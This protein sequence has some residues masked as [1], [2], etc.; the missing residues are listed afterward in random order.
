MDP[1]TRCLLDCGMLLRDQSEAHCLS[2]VCK[3][4][5]EVFV[6]VVIGDLMPCA[7]IPAGTKEVGDHP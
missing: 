3:V 1:G 4:M 5:V 7:L 2:D 6:V